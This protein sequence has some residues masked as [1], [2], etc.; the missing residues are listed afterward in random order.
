MLLTI[1]QAD[2]WQWFEE[3]MTYDNAILP[4]ALLHSCEITGNDEAKRAVRS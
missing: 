1:L 3:G 4:L 2:D